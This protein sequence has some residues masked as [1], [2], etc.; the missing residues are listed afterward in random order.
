MIRPT[1]YRE[2][3][4]TK[5]TDPTPAPATA[6]APIPPTPASVHFG[7]IK[8]PPE[9]DGAFAGPHEE[10]SYAHAVPYSEDKGA[11]A[12]DKRPYSPE[13]RPYSEDKKPYPAAY[14][15]T[16]YHIE[17]ADEHPRSPVMAGAAGVAAAPAVTETSRVEEEWKQEEPEYMTVP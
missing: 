2:E 14:G 5:T 10:R 3:E 11:Y 9:H 6:A 7:E 8:T 4:H 17:H 15:S 1:I 12:G 16:T 13:K